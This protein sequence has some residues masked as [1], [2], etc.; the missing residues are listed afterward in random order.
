MHSWN[1]FLNSDLWRQ[2]WP[3]PAACLYIGKIR[4]HAFVCNLHLCK[5]ITV[6]CNFTYRHL[7]NFRDT[8]YQGTYRFVWKHTR[9]RNL[10]LT[11]HI[12]FL[13]F[14]LGLHI[15]YMLLHHFVILFWQLWYS[16]SPCTLY[17]QS[18]S[19]GLSTAWVDKPWH[20]WSMFLLW[21]QN[22]RKVWPHDILVATA[23]GEATLTLNWDFL[24]SSD[25]RCR[26]QPDVGLKTL[27]PEW[28]TASLSDLQAWKF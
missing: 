1:N 18:F 8:W 13:S 16:S 15:Q 3:K 28:C 26:C 5:L 27:I 22:S 17:S 10:L 7:L 2:S 24:L 4:L 12:T 19:C 20:D 14:L 9:F 21:T 11:N 6:V 25:C 23:I